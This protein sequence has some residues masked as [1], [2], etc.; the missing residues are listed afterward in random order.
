MLL[1][2]QDYRSYSESLVFMDSVY[3]KPYALSQVSRRWWRF[4][5]NSKST[6]WFLCNLSDGPL[7]ASGRLAVSRSF[8]DADILMSGQHRLD[9]RSS[10]SNFFKE[11]DFSRHYLRSF[12]KTSGWHGNL[13]GHYLAF[14]NNPGF[15]YNYR[16]ELQWRPSGCSTKPSGCGPIMGRIALF[17]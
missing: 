13:S 2:K 11:L 3:L 12:C 17:W 16:N 1:F 5:A 7:K 9:T 14:Q 4:H 15:L 10:F 8:R 6:S